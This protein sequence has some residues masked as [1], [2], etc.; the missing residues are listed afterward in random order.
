M[1]WSTLM[2]NIYNTYF[3]KAIPL[4]IK[5]YDYF[6]R[7][8]KYP[9]PNISLTHV[10]IKDRMQLMHEVKAQYPNWHKFYET[11][12]KQ[13]NSPDVFK[14]KDLEKVEKD[15]NKLSQHQVSEYL[16]L[17]VSS[18]HAQPENKK[19]QYFDKKN[20][21]ENLK[22]LTQQLKAQHLHVADMK[23]WMSMF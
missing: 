14:P 5:N 2:E 11:I 10:P 23:N 3:T 12:M 15:V 17:L 22:T 4:H 9:Q 20:H 21:H 18:K 7:F 13:I 8:G 16:Y 19:G 1:K 6:I